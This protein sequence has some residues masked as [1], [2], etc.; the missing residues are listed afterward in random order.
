MRK[1]EQNVVLNESSEALGNHS[2]IVRIL[3]FAMATAKN[4]ANGSNSV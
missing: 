1:I 2:E 3:V 4:G